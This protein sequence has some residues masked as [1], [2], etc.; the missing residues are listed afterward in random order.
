MK[1]ITK[2][3]FWALV[4]SVIALFISWQSC[5]DVHQQLVLTSGQVRSYVQETEVKLLHPINQ[6]SFVKIQLK[7]KNFGQTAALNVEGD[8]D[9]E[10]GSTI[11]ASDNI[12]T[13]GKFGS[14][15]PGFERI[16]TLTSNRRN[17]YG[18]FFPPFPRGLS[19]YFYGTIWYTDA[20]TNE[21]K[22]T[23][24]CYELPLN[25]DTDT[26]KTDLQKSTLFEYELPGNK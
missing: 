20:T 14:M 17:N 15:G 7:I 6:G 18:D 8:F 5:R 10:K 4:I 3:E 12:A 1:I 19:V 21:R 16:I 23:D 26:S 22:H 25:N 11:G 13:L 9:Y 2:L 24:W